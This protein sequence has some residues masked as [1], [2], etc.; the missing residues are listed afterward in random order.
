MRRRPVLFASLAL[1][2]LLGLGGTLLFGTAWPRSPA[3]AADPAVSDLAVQGTAWV[4]ETPG[5][6]ALFR[7]YGWGTAVRRK[8]TGASDQWVHIPFAMFTFLEDRG[9][10][11]KF[12]EF[13]AQSTNGA[14]TKPTRIDLWGNKSSF[15]SQA[16]AWPA[17]NAYHCSQV[18]LTPVWKE[19][20][21][22]SVRLHFANA[23]DTI[24]LF[25]A[26]VQ[27]TD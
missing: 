2:L 19:S 27:T 7:H 11:L 16:I 24:T 8:S 15:L 12:V 26:W 10:K 9:Q 13:C 23:T 21:G 5:Q 17:T 14:A 6:L 25:K 18:T 22:I 4:A 20:F 3:R 1:V